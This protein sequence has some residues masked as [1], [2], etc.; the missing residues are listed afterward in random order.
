MDALS[1]LFIIRR[2][3]HQCAVRENKLCVVNTMHDSTESV[4]FPEALA[5]FARRLAE[6]RLAVYSVAYDMLHFGSWTLEVGR[7]HRRIRLAWDGKESS[8]DLAVG[9]SGSSNVAVDW[10]SVSQSRLSARD[11]A[12][13]LA[14]A[15]ELVLGQLNT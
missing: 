4:V 1:G 10:M 12:S 5:D 9:S 3:N 6:N 2:V 11:H 8:L 14:V 7:R 15:E 13:V